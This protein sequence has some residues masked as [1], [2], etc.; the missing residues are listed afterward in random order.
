MVVEDRAGNRGPRILQHK[1]TLNIVAYQF[2]ARLRV[3]DR[4]L[5]AE[6]R[7]RRRAGLRLNSAREGCDD[8]RAGLRLP[9]RVDDGALALPDV[10][11]IPVPRLRVDGLADAPEHTQARQVVALDV[12]VAQAAEKTDGS[13]C[14]VELSDLVLVDGFPVP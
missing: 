11:V 13:R 3:Q 9:E 8:D 5:D 4:R 1:H 2:L 6:E 10:L 14:G 7:H 12:M